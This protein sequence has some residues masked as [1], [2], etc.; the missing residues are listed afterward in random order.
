MDQQNQDK[1]DATGKT[2]TAESSSQQQQSQTSSST[3]TVL[4]GYQGQYCSNLGWILDQAGAKRLWS[5]SLRTPFMM[6]LSP[7][8]LNG[9][10]VFKSRLTVDSAA[11]KAYEYTLS[12]QNCLEMFET[13]P[14]YLLCPENFTIPSRY[15]SYIATWNLGQKFTIN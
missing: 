3:S 4:T 6:K 7:A 8:Y 13:N 2:T 12:K 15:T 11:F 14:E 1:T 5:T 9:Y 10:L